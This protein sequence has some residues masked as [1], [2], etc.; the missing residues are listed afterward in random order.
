MTQQLRLLNRDGQPCTVNVE[1]LIAI[2]PTADG[3][4][5][6][7]KDGM[8]FYPST[9][10]EMLLMY[11]DMGFE[12]LDRTNMVNMNHV[13][14]FDPKARKVYFDYP[15]NESSKFATVSE[16]NVSKVIHL[17]KEDKA[18]YNLIPKPSFFWK[19]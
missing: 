4:E 17:A 16:A 7:T 5:F 19:K 13:K 14:A 11:K 18:K 10:E 12:R 8:Y 2:K 6:Y 1:D 3:P 15:W 9:M